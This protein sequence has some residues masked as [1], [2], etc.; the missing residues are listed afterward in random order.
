[1]RIRKYLVD[2][3]LV[4]A[5]IVIVGVLARYHGTQTDTKEN[6]IFTTPIVEPATTDNNY[7]ISLEFSAPSA[8]YNRILNLSVVTTDGNVDLGDFIVKDIRLWK[9]DG[10]RII[11]NEFSV[12]SKPLFV[13]LYEHNGT[14]KT[15]LYEGE[16][17]EATT[18]EP[19]D[20][21]DN[22]QLIIS[23]AAPR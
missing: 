22:E 4:V 2:I 8:M 1:M 20:S 7:T 17:E 6:S 15:K 13:T 23:V 3:F 5:I 16:I 9:V 11:N 12:A 19:I 18:L 14:Q 10:S 21:Q